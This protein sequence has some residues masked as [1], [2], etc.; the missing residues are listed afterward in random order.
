MSFF[1]V[2]RLPIAVAPLF[3]FF[4]GNLT[5]DAQDTSA[6]THA[7]ATNAPK[8]DYSF[9]ARSHW[10]EGRGVFL[11]KVRSDGTVQSVDVAKSTG[12]RELDQSAVAALQRWQFKP[13]S[14]T[15]VKIPMEFTLA[16]LRP[17]V[18]DAALR[19]EK[20]GSK[21]PRRKSSWSEY[22]EGCIS[23]WNAYH[24]PDYEEYFRKRRGQLGLVDLDK[25]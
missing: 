20:Q 12:H 15:A 6:P 4:L 7:L 13:G 1:P 21:P 9:E 3:F 23:A 25:L 18:I 8:P 17:A 14:V 10:L 16:G 5:I 11:L 22:W 24:R 19:A 2:R